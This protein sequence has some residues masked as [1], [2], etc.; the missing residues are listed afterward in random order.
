MQR[1]SRAQKTLLTHL[2]EWQ[3]AARVLS[4]QEAASELGYQAPSAIHRL[5]GA[6]TDRG[7]IIRGQHLHQ[8][9]LTDAG[10]QA[11]QRQPPQSGIPVL[12]AIAA[13]SPILAEEH[14]SGWL[15]DLSPRSSRFAL[16]VRG[17][18][19]IGDG[20][21]DGDLAVIDSEKSIHDGSIAAILHDGEA[22][23]KHVYR[24]Q[25][26]LRLVASNPAVPDRMLP[27][28][29]DWRILGGLHLVVRA[30]SD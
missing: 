11:L 7:L 3:E 26:G 1:L 18:S 20:I 2:A 24:L 12:G 29:G 5:V 16:C 23:L 6:L 9:R 14:I 30:P 13:G 8:T 27:A 19:M 22:T 28:D 25:G 17:D 10:W 15:P 21:L 4:Y